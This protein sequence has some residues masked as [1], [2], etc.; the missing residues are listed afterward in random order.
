[1]PS[2][3]RKRIPSNPYA[4]KFSLF[5]KRKLM[6][7][8]R[9]MPSPVFKNLPTVARATFPKHR[10]STL[11]YV[12]TITLN[13][14]P[15]SFSFNQFRCNSTFDPDAS[16]G[17]HQPYGFDQWMVL[18]K[19]FHVISSKI[20]IIA[21]NS[22]PGGATPH[23]WRFGITPIERTGSLPVTTNDLMEID[24]AKFDMLSL[25]NGPRRLTASFDT[26][27]YFDVTNVMDNDNLGGSITANPV[28][29]YYWMVW[30]ANGS[31]SA[32]DPD[33]LDIVVCIDYDVIFTGLN[34]VTNS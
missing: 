15:A 16:L 11:R 30:A 19:T 1:M 32:V 10:R 21:T 8:T 29:Q 6:S 14:G 34:D 18:Y 22:A 2:F 23:N 17:G 28:D 20:T 26:A 3:K 27:K 7:L 24:G 31:N 5:K 25:D 12:D 9:A 33:P 4:N 13:P